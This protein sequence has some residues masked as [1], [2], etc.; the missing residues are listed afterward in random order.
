ML[1]NSWQMLRF[2][3]CQAGY[4]IRGEKGETLLPK[5][6]DFLYLLMEM[7]FAFKHLLWTIVC[8]TPYTATYWDVSV[9]L[10]I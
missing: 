4:P 3:I 10:Q 5:W 6:V 2:G 7:A 9:S 8:V 1:A